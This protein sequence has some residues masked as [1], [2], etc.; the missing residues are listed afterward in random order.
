MPLL[1]DMEVRTGGLFKDGLF[2]SFFCE[3][4]VVIMYNSPTI[5][6]GSPLA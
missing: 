5:W 6:I 2:F 4:I 3:S 1:S